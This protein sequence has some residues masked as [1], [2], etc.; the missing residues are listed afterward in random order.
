M[1][2]TWSSTWLWYNLQVRW[3]ELNKITMQCKEQKDTSRQVKKYW[4]LTWYLRIS[5]LKYEA[6]GFCSACFFRRITKAL[7][8]NS[9]VI[10]FSSLWLHRNETISS[11]IYKN[12]CQHKSIYT[13]LLN[14]NNN[15]HINEFL[16]GNKIVEP[17]R[18][19]YLEG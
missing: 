2:W 5:T 14:N 10:S 8:L 19:P 11:E 18:G 3:F 1:Q 4:N 6:F 12:L 16:I 13:K 15:L 17:L 7:M 9:N